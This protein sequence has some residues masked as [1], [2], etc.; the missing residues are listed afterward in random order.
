MTTTTLDRPDPLPCGCDDTGLCPQHQQALKP[1]ELA[2]LRA[3]VR[4][5]RGT[6]RGQGATPS[7]GDAA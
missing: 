4:G 5:S 1:R 3:R 2:A 6:G 7:G